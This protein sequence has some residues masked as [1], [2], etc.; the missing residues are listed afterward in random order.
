MSTKVVMGVRLCPVFNV[1]KLLNDI[2]GAR[3]V[4]SDILVNRKLQTGLSGLLQ[5][6]ARVS[7]CL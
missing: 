7:G 2:S 1:I 4:I 6:S 3:L 5:V